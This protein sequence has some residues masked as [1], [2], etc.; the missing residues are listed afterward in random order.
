MLKVRLKFTDRH[1]DEMPNKNLYAPDYSVHECD[2]KLWSQLQLYLLG[3]DQ[4]KSRINTS[5]L[6]PTGNL[7]DLSCV[8]PSNTLKV[9][10]VCGV[11]TFLFLIIM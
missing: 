7:K 10:K 4:S 8:H 6:S 5:V 11:H 3:Y 1:T 9:N 2:K